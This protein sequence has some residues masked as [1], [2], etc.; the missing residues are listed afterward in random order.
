MSRD[1]TPATG[2][3]RDERIQAAFMGLWTALA[4]IAVAAVVA[5]A[6][7]L[8][9]A[10]VGSGSKPDDTDW[11]GFEW[12]LAAIAVGPLAAAVAGPLIA[13]RLRLAAWPAFF[14]PVLAAV[15]V[16]Y[17]T[18]GF[19]LGSVALVITAVVIG[20]AGGLRVR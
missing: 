11:E 7:V 2:K 13:R 4:Q 10:A 12:V 16:S 15:A 18:G 8:I 6:L 5:I 14:C 19:V 1:H 17:G 3:T 20:Y 9:G